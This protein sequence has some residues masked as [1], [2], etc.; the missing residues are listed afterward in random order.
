MLLPSS[1][2]DAVLNPKL[3]RYASTRLSQYVKYAVHPEK[4]HFHFSSHPCKESDLA[5]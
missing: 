1:G 4:L 3:T 5:L 2:N